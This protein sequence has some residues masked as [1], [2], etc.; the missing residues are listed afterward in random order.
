MNNVLNWLPV[1][2]CISCICI[3]P[4]KNNLS[5]TNNSTYKNASCVWGSGAESVCLQTLCLLVCEHSSWA[6]HVGLQQLCGSNETGFLSWRKPDHLGFGTDCRTAVDTGQILQGKHCRGLNYFTWSTVSLYELKRHALI[7][8]RHV[9]IWL[10]EFLGPYE[11]R[12]VEK[13]DRNTEFSSN[14]TESA[15]FLNE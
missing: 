15:K 11:F 8:F 14:T 10:L 3:L 12:D 1:I 6:L 4:C 9:T 2:Y 7:G 5:T 13:V